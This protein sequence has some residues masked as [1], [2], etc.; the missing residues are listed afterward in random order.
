MISEPTIPNV[1]TFT[2]L[3]VIIIC[4]RCFVLISATHKKRVESS[5]NDG[6]SG[7]AQK[8]HPHA[9]SED[10]FKTQQL[11][12][13]V[14]LGSGGHSTEMFHLLEELD[15]QIYT[16][17]VYVVANSDTTSIA[18]LKRYIDEARESSNAER[19]DRWDGRYPIEYET[20]CEKHNALLTYHTTT[21]SDIPIKA[22]VHR[23]PRPR[24]VH[25]SYISSTFSTLYSIY[26]TVHMIIREQPDLILANG[27]GL[28]AMVT[29]FIVVVRHKA[30]IKRTLQNDICRVFVPRSNAFA[31]R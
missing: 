24:E 6:Y 22:R 23:L 16:P 13:L 21:E 26:H 18:R 7:R 12:A 17:I 4:V 11:K 30:A 27:P 19:I 8:I 25:Q 31:V 14:V 28:I 29:A 9:R 15:P 5:C 1:T 10:G 3:F 2:S 20:Y